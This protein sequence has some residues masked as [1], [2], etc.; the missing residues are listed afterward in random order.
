[1][2]YWHERGTTEI[3]ATGPRRRADKAV[4]QPPVWEAYT[5]TFTFSVGA[6]AVFL[7]LSNR[8][9]TNMPNVPVGT[10]VTVAVSGPCWTSSVWVTVEYER[11]V[12][13]LPLLAVLR[14]CWAP[15]GTQC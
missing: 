6:E 1:M 13:C 2:H 12:P 4:A 7:M 9:A 15:R 3:V 11:L 14:T 8:F 10:A 5:S